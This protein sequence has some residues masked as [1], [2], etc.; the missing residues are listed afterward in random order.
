[1]PQGVTWIQVVA[2]GASANTTNASW[3]TGGTVS[4]IIPVTPGE[5]LNLYVGS[6]PQTINGLNTI[7]YNGGGTSGHGIEGFGGGGTDIRKGG[8]ALSN[9]VIVAGGGAGRSETFAVKNPSIL[10]CQNRSHA[11]FSSTGAAWLKWILG[12]INRRRRLGGFRRG[13]SRRREFLGRRAQ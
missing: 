3:N 12:K 1:M 13:R 11:R 4:A 6:R 8:D 9:R 2:R 10:Q 5:V 7:G